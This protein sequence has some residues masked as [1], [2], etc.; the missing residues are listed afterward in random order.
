MTTY[1]Y[2]SPNLAATLKVMLDVSKDM[3]TVVS[4][5]I[6]VAYNS[7][8]I[9]TDNGHV[10]HISADRD[11]GDLKLSVTSTEGEVVALLS[12]EPHHPQ[13][14]TGLLTSFITLPL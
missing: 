6:D 1:H 11:N 5:G 7:F 13:V 2:L 9:E 8:R 4:Y 10:I 3:K 14:I 12:V